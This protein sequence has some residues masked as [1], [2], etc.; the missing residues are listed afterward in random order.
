MR[1]MP[2]MI[3]AAV[4]NVHMTT[5]FSCKICQVNI[6]FFTDFFSWGL[7]FCLL[8]YMQSEYI[9]NLSTICMRRADV[10][11]IGKEEGAHQDIR[12]EKNKE[13]SWRDGRYY[14]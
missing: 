1:P 9:Y 7:C 6:M 3:I 5:F 8:S 11:A 14:V 2:G 4:F 12:Y 13:G 10:F